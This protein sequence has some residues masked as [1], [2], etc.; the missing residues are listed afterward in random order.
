MFAKNLLAERFTFNERNRFKSA[1][2]ALGGIA[3]STDA[4]ECIK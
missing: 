1:N 2:N 3:E 4:A